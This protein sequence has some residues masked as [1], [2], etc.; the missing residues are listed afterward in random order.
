MHGN[1][2]LVRQDFAPEQG[3]HRRPPFLKSALSQ[4]GDGAEQ[5]HAQKESA[6]PKR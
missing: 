1:V 6:L 5:Q 3:F 2:G 4:N